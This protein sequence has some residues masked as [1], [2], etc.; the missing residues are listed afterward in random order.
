MTA[1]CPECNKIFKS[2]SWPCPN[3]GYNGIYKTKR[4]VFDLDIIDAQKVYASEIWH[5]KIDMEFH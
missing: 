1:Q 3:C 5:P 2:E 4:T